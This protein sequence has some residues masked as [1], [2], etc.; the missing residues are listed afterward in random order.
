M[1]RRAFAV[2]LMEGDLGVLRAGGLS[3]LSALRPDRQL[4]QGALV[5]NPCLLTGPPT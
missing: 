2:P 1:L 4:H 3:F 5:S